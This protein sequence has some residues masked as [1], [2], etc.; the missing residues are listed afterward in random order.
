VNVKIT[1]FWDVMASNLVN[2][3]GH[4]GG[5]HCLQNV[6][7]YLSTKLHIATSQKCYLKNANMSEQC[8]NVVLQLG[9]DTVTTQTK[10]L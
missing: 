4:S 1:V 2:C 5:M 6:D 7:T 8:L 10:N 3:Y 9:K